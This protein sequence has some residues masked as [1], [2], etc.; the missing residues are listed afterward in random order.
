MSHA[1]IS[2]D[3]ELLEYCQR[4]A[5]AKQIA[6][7]TE[8]VAERTYW[9]V[10]CLVQ[11][12]C[13]GQEA[14][15]DALA[16]K[17]MT[18]F[19]QA[20]AQPGHQ[21]VVHAGRCELE[22]CLR[23][24]GAPPAGLVDVQ[25]AAGLVGLEYPAAYHTLVSRLL[26]KTPRKE[27]TRTDWRRRPLSLRQIAYALEDVRDLPALHDVLIARIAR[28]GRQTWL[29]ED[30][31]VW[32]EE[33][34]DSLNE[35]RWWRVSGN[36]GLSRRSLAILR[37]LWHWREAEAQ[38]RNCP[39]RRLLRDDLLV[40]LARRQT[41]DPR[42]L[43]ALRGLDRPDLKRQLPRVAEAIQRALALP[44]QECPPPPARENPPHLSVLGQL[45][46]SA[47]GN[48]CRQAEL[49]PALVGTPTDVR[50]WIAFRTGEH[51]SGRLPRLARGWRAELIGQ[52]FE[53]LLAGKLLIRVA[54][55]GS[56]TPL[57]FEPYPPP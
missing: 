25:I 57:R 5:C 53:Q 56:Q 10:L 46:F 36:S 24:A 9:P 30:M 20:L 14:L 17:E 54:D 43:H 50:D 40:E 27:E 12:V 21:T 49:A 38:R 3:H 55:P 31:S 37:E 28:L 44:E 47:L 29:Q 32:Q 26:G 11:V 7:D 8:F 19:W 16:V 6:L 18:P 41:A 15:I 4:L 52:L 39:P 13:D 51:P 23:A 33:V 1:T 2:T 35:P 42:R 45:L 22:F 34:K 48:V